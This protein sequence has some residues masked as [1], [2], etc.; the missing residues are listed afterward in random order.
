MN[1]YRL[2]STVLFL[3]ASLF[4]GTGAQSLHGD[5]AFK[6]G[7]DRY[8]KKVE[9]PVSPA[10]KGLKGKKTSCFTCHEKGRKGKDAKKFR[11][12]YGEQFGKL[13]AKGAK[14][15]EKFDRK[16]YAKL[17]K[18]GFKSSKDPKKPSEPEK[19]LQAIFKGLEKLEA[20]NKKKYGENF[21]KGLT[22]DALALKKE[23]AKKD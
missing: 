8:Y 3:V 22:P 5:A 2:R 14:K 10:Q 6:M 16:E 9:S 12:P 15:D 19:R 23:A 17:L 21:A 11:N 18:A 1:Y 7:Y 13:L 4:I 20:S